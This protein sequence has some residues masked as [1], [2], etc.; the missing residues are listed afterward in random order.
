MD[1]GSLEHP[2]V[3]VL[4]L[5]GISVDMRWEFSAGVGQAIM[6]KSSLQDCVDTN[7]RDVV[8][9]SGDGLCVH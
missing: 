6:R 7:T 8:C 5:N 9:Q 3:E 1:G 2:T 4:R